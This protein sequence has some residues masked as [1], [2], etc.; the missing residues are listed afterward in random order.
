MKKTKVAYYPTCPECQFEVVVFEKSEEGIPKPV[1]QG[2]G[3]IIIA[4]TGIKAQDGFIDHCVY[5]NGDFKDLS[6]QVI[7]IATVIGKGVGECVKER[8]GKAETK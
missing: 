7:A 8:R 2:Y 4:A 5:L 6:R 3:E 1:F